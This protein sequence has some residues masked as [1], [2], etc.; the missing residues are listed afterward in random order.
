[1]FHDNFHTDDLRPRAQR[2]R[3]QSSAERGLPSDNDLTALA[4]TYL[5]IQQSLWPEPVR[6]RRWQTGRVI[7][8]TRVIDK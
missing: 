4:R 1:M 3:K 8:Y 2:R 6:R 5:E 7:L